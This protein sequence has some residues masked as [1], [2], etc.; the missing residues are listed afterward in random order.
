MAR[1]RHDLRRLQLRDTAYEARCVLREFAGFLFNSYLL[2]AGR[3]EPLSL[4][5]FPVNVVHCSYTVACMVAGTQPED[6]FRVSFGTLMLSLQ[7]CSL[8]F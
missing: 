4:T 2:R 5:V 6:V 1:L 3:R 7:V 8:L